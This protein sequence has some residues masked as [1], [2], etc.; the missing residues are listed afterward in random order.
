M[1]PAAL[2][3]FASAHPVLVGI[4]GTIATLLIVGYIVAN[5][6]K[7]S[8]PSGMVHNQKHNCGA[9]NASNS[10]P[11]PCSPLPTSGFGS[12]HTAEEVSAGI[13][14]SNKVAIVTGANSGIGFETAR[15]LALRGAHVIV[16]SRSMAKAEDA[17][18]RMTPT[19]LNSRAW[20]QRAAGSGAKPAFTPM[21]CDLADLDS[22]AAFVAAF[23][24]KSLPLHILVCNAGIMALRERQTTKQGIERQVGTNHVGHFALTVPLLAVMAQSEG[25]KRVVCV[26]SLGHRNA[27]ASFLTS[28]KLESSSYHPWKAYGNSKLANI[29]MAREISRRCKVDAPSANITAYSL[30]PGGIHTNLQTE[31]TLGTRIF[32]ALVTPFFFKSIP[33]GAATSVYCA[34]AKALPQTGAGLYYDNCNVKAPHERVAQLVNDANGQRLWKTSEALTG[35]KWPL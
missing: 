19:I 13:D 23:Q 31:V 1:L 25:D 29:L 34:T 18:Q 35:I 26:S 27:S 24:A 28:P 9:T 8:G 7:R 11:R 17:I 16:V 6:V 15:V 33:Q 3:S 21:V 20:Q 12:S 22:V 4:V 14:L 32:W 5:F 30:H 2:Q 10:C